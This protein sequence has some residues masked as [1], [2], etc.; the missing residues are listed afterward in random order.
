MATNT[1]AVFS[2]GIIAGSASNATGRVEIHGGIVRTASIGLAT[3][4]FSRGEYYQDGGTLVNLGELALGSYSA[5]ANKKMEAQAVFNGGISSNKTISVGHSRDRHTVGTMIVSNGLVC[6]D[7]L[8]VA[9]SGTGFLFVEGGELCIRGDV[10]Q[11]N[12]TGEV[13]GGKSTESQIFLN[14][15]VLSATRVMHC[16]HSG[17]P[18]FSRLVFNGGTLRAQADSDCLIGPNDDE[19]I[20]YVG[21]VGNTNEYEVAL[22]GK[23]GTIDTAGHT[24]VIPKALTGDGALTK[25]GAGMLELT[26]KNLYRG[27]T[28]VREGS[29]VANAVYAPNVTLDGGSLLVPNRGEK[30]SVAALAVSSGKLRTEIS[31]STCDTLQVAGDVTWNEGASLVVSPVLNPSEAIWGDF[32]LLS[33]LSADVTLDRF[34]VEPVKGYDIRLSLK[35]GVLSARIRKNNGFKIIIR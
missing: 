19:L 28:I 24:V 6:A 35:D 30:P 14:G 2:S 22:N 29:L 15:G 5:Q 17:N 21:G 33:G 13:E 4:P 16:L 3:S 34:S 7:N 32:A 18:R 23:G 10:I 26:G 31:S 9:N 25:I 1:G 20:S 8:Y 11:H 27:G 12:G